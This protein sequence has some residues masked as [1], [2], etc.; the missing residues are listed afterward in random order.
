MKT[1]TLVE[2]MEHVSALR[3]RR[4]VIQTCVDYLRSHYRATAAGDPEFRI[5]R[6]DYAVVPAQHI[7]DTLL[8]FDTVMGDLDIELSQ[9]TAAR[10][11][12]EEQS[13]EEPES[14]EDVIRIV[15]SKENGNGSRKP[16]ARS[17]NKGAATKAG[18]V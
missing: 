2:A 8:F 17:D 18:A 7:E 6:E 15:A 12:P 11:V 14:L 16:K 9:M 5:T 4:A 1:R 10:V 13:E 3:S